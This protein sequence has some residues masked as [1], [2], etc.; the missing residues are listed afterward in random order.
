MG[1]S[2]YHHSFLF[3]MRTQDGYAL[4]LLLNTKGVVALIMLNIAWDRMVLIC[5]KLLFTPFFNKS[6][7]NNING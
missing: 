3:G 5:L 1:V 6:H 7:F 2:M 4:G